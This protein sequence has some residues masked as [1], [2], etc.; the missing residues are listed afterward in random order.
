MIKSRALE[1]LDTQEISLD[2]AGKFWFWSF[3]VEEED[4]TCPVTSV[5]VEEISQEG[6]NVVVGDVSTDN[7]VSGGGGG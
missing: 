1:I 4:S 7:H 2:E 3:V 5:R 6:L